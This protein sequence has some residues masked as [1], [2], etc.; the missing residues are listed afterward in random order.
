MF[1]D[2]AIKSLRQPVLRYVLVDAELGIYLGGAM[3]LG[4]WSKLDSV[5][6]N[7]A[8]TFPSQDE[9]V[10]HALSWDNKIPS[11]VVMPI[12]LPASTPTMPNGSMYATIEDCVRAGLEGWVK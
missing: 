12:E 9:A 2:Q 5:G 10:K 8:I 4:F 6:Q 3:G 1:G 7:T 11:V